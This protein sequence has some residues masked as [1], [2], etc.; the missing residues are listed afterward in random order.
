MIGALI[1]AHAHDTLNWQAM[2][3]PDQV[4]VVNIILLNP[5]L[6]VV[7]H[8]LPHDRVLSE[9]AVRDQLRV[10]HSDRLLASRGCLLR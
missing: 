6:E 8:D 3:T 5:H 4:S 10:A 9:E 7:F 2:I 1:W